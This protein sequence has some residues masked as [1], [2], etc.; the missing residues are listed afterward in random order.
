MFTLNRYLEVDDIVWRDITSIDKKYEYAWIHKFI[1]KWMS[2]ELLF[3]FCLVSLALVAVLSLKKSRKVISKW[4]FKE[5]HNNR[6]IVTLIVIVIISIL[7]C[8]FF[9]VLYGLLINET[10][11][12]GNKLGIEFTTSSELITK[13]HL[14]DTEMIYRILFL[15]TLNYFLFYPVLKIIRFMSKSEILVDIHCSNGTCFYE[16]HLISHNIDNNFLLLC[17]TSNIFDSN[18]YLI[19]K[20]TINYIKFSTIHYNFGLVARTQGESPLALPDD[21]TS[22]EKCMVMNLNEKSIDAE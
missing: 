20:N 9:G 7:H 14:Y 21:F 19:S 16:K 1:T 4:I 22:E 13:I 11:I 17:D 10:L 2:S 8:L 18:K 12:Q 3:L 6:K 15:T 5:K